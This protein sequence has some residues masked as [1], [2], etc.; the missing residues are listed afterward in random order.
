VLRTKVDP[1]PTLWEAILPPEF[2]ALPPGLERI[3]RLLDDPVFFEPFVPFF[4]PVMGRPSIPIETY[5]RMM[6]L[7]FRYRLGFETLCGEVTD[8]LTWR[9][10][11]RIGI[12]DTVPD[13]S[14]LMKITTRCGEVTVAALNEKLL[15]KADAAHLIKVDKVR[16]DTTVVPANVAYPTDSG[17]LAKG[18]AKLTRCRGHQGSRAGAPNALS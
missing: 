2:S 18:V 6:F 16:A 13:P 14:T 8:S 11:C 1:Q 9:R 12:T 17:L 5:L 7:R 10:F 15:E 4:N 3:D